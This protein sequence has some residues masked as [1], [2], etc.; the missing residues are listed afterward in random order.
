MRRAILAAACFAFPAVHAAGESEP[1]AKIQIDESTLVGTPGFFRVGRTADGRWWLVDPAGKAFHYRGVCAVNRVGL[2][3]GRWAKRGPYADVVDRKYG[4]APGPFVEATLAR[5]RAWG[6]NALGAWTAEEFFD[7]DMPYTEVLMLNYLGTPLNADGVT[8]PDVHDPAWAAAVDAFCAKLCAPRK[9]SKLLIGYFTDNE[10]V[11]AAPPEAIAPEAAIEGGFYR[12]AR[13]SLLQQCLMI[14]D[15]RPARRAAWDFLIERH[16]D[17]AGVAK[18]WGMPIPDRHAPRGWTTVVRAEVRDPK[19]KTPILD[20]KTGKKVY[21][22]KAV[23]KALVTPGYLKDCEAWVGECLRRYHAITAAAIRRH[24]PNHLILGQRFGAYPGRVVLAACRRPHIDVCSYNT[25][26][27]RTLGEAEAYWRSAGMPLLVGEYA[28][29]SGHY[30]KTPPAPPKPVDLTQAEKIRQNGPPALEAL[31]AHPA[32]VGYTWYR[33][34]DL[35][36]QRPPFGHG[37]V[38]LE[39]EPNKLHT[40]LLTAVN[41][42]AESIAAEVDPKAPRE[43]VAFPPLGA[44]APKTA[45]GEKKETKGPSQA[46]TKP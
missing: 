8:C 10:L 28:W 27:T 36:D 45:A 30:I 4:V 46:P 14:E 12:G 16:G 29:V 17:L 15:A 2:M 11:W 24:D 41:A 3:G 22:D 34:V 39:D 37:L 43:P 31:V 20:P 5:L 9:D 42:K 6:F 7:R 18:A 21:E 40:D 23:S 38:M 19:T 1:L 33:W 25:Y 26:R 44:T 13:A 32:I 35:P